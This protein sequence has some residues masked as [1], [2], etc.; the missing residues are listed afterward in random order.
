[1]ATV[2]ILNFCF[3]LPALPLVDALAADK[4]NADASKF[5]LLRLNA[6]ALPSG[7][8]GK[9]VVDFVK[10]TFCFALVAALVGGFAG[11]GALNRTALAFGILDAG[12]VRGAVS[13]P[14]KAGKFS[15]VRARPLVPN[16]REFSATFGRVRTGAFPSKGNSCS[17]CASITRRI[18]IDAVPLDSSRAVES[19]S[20]FELS[21]RL[22]VGRFLGAKLN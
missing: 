7:N 21:C 10:F 13:L 5:R 18:Y 20:L 2:A 9:S 15:F 17:F 1:M 3:V 19:L 8:A 14:P 6:D 16:G 22:E 12:E 11:V 4:L